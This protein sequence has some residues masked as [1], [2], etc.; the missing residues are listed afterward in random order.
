MVLETEL[1]KK[2]YNRL[3]GC[4]GGGVSLED[5]VVTLLDFWEEEGDDGK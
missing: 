2:T 4:M 3:C 1:S 5:V